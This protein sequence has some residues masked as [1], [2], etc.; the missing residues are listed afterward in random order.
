MAQTDYQ[1]QQTSPALSSPQTGI[2]HSSESFGWRGIVVEQRYHPAG[3][4]IFPR[5]SRTWFLSLCFLFANRLLSCCSI[6]DMEE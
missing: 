5:S 3:E 2:L 1:Q 6:Y 4:Y